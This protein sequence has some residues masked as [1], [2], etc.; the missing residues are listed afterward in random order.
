MAEAGE[1]PKRLPSQEQLL[2]DYVRQGGNLYVAAG[3][4]RLGGSTNEAAVWNE[5]LNP[6]GL[7][8]SPRF[9]TLT[10]PGAGVLC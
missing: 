7:S 4:A 1:A 2:V 3:T 5:V 10:D 8:Y 9:D 6:F